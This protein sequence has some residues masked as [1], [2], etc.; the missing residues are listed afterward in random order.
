MRLPLHRS[1]AVQSQFLF[2]QSAKRGEGGV[3][4]GGLWTLHAKTTADQTVFG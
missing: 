3:R 1:R 4:G 2:D